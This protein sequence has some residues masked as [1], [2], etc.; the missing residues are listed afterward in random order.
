MIKNSFFKVLLFMLLGFVTSWDCMQNVQG[1]VFDS[2]S[3]EPLD[4]VYVCKVTEL[5]G[6][7]TDKNGKF[8]INGISGGLFRCPSMKVTLNKKGYKR[9]ILTLENYKS[10]VIYLEK[11]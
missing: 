2:V 1:V 8:E 7:Y 9:Q 6:K 10:K 4:S 3:K 11:E 5:N